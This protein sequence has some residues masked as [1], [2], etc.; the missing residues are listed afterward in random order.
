VH[1]H[2]ERRIAQSGRTIAPPKPPGD[3][4]KVEK[5]RL[6]PPRRA[7]PRRDQS[8]VDAERRAITVENDD[9]FD[10]E[11]RPAVPADRSRSLEHVLDARGVRSD[12]G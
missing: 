11:R 2:N 6:A 3:A 9:A 4:Q 7:D 8:T 12:L 5:E 1:T 10:T